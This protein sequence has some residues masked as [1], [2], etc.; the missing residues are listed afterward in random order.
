[1]KRFSTLSRLG[2]PGT[3]GNLVRRQTRG[4]FQPAA[5]VEERGQSRDLPDRLLIPAALSQQ[6]DIVFVHQA[7]RLR[8]LAGV[9]EQLSGLVIQLVLGPFRR[10]FMTEVLIS[11]KATNRRRMETESRS[12][13]H[14]AVDDC[15]QHLTL[16]TAEG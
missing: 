9:A 13:T 12:P 15:R 1:M 11:G 8:Q 5:E 16:E 4:C 7:R 10:E 2:N 14:L 6:A 3:L